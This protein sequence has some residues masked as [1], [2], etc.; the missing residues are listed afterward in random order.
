MISSTAV[1][2]AQSKLLEAGLANPDSLRG[3]T[4][5]EIKCIESRFALRL[6][7]CYRDFLLIMGRSAGEF[8]VG[9]DYSYPKVFAFRNDAEELLRT[10][11]SDIKLSPSSFVFMF[12]QGHTFLY[13]HCNDDSD[14]PPVFMFTEIEKE[15]RKVA[16]SFS[17]WLLTAVE[18]DI[19]AYREL[20]RD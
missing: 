19:S 11:R 6:P 4:E 15:P 13:F 3:C 17:A 1:R 18:D 12:H 8:L 9:T 14:D 20:K 5:Q 10:N 16:D 7:R 2:T